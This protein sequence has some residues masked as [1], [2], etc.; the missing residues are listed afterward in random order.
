MIP[1]A[2]SR[3]DPVAPPVFVASPLSDP[4]Q[5]LWGGFVARLLGPHEVEAERDRVTIRTAAQDDLPAILELARRAIA[6]VPPT[7]YSAADLE[8]WSLESMRG[9]GALV[10][11]GRYLVACDSSGRVVAQGGWDLGPGAGTG[12]VRALFTDPARQGEGLG[13]SM[14]IAIEGHLR[15]AGCTLIV[16][17]ASLNAAG[18]YARHGYSAE[19]QELATLAGRTMPVLW[20]EKLSVALA[21]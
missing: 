4:S 6:A 15:A 5:P 11:S 1:F 17:A 3:P 10:A 18:F 20:M 16:V 12:T 14:L 19:E 2:Q 21:A 8:A 7:R 9:L 13:R